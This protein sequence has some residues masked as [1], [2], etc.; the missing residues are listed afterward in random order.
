MTLG[1]KQEK[2]A[3]CLAQLLLRIA[4]DGYR[5][6][7]RELYRAPETAKLYSETCIRCP[8]KK[9]EHVGKDHAF[10]ARGVANSVHTQ[11]LAID[12]LLV[13]PDGEV[14]LS[15]NQGHY[16]PIGEFWEKLSEHARWGGRFSDPGHFSFEHGGVK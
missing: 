14:Q 11:G 7:L 6:R 2:F 9:G 8:W 16:T 5:T 3:V 10:K 4:A 1:D 12:L 13:T 15:D